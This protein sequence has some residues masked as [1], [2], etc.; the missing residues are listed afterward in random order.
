[1]LSPGYCH[2]LKQPVHGNKKVTIIKYY[3]LKN[4]EAYKKL[5]L[6]CNNHVNIAK[7][8][9]YKKQFE[10]YQDCSKKQ[11]QIIYGLL[12]RN[13]K[14]EQLRLKDSDGSIL[15]SEVTVAERFL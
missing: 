11:W 4:T 14:T 1:M 2:G 12:G 8:R 6:F 3:Y 13:R 15:S 10:K 7:K 5:K 9:Y